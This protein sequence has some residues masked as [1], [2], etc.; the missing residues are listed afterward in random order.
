MA[1]T[2]SP[3]D[4]QHSLTAEVDFDSG[5]DDRSLVF[6]VA[7]RAYACQVSAVREVVPLGRVTRLPG[8]PDSVLGLINVRGSIVTVVNA[9]AVLHPHDAGAPLRMVLIADVGVRGVGLAVERVADV[10]ALRPEEGYTELDVR[11]VAMRVVAI[12]EDE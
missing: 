12:S 1:S 11:D 10:R 7:G 6:R 3:S 9:G 2:I 5:L 4:A 8:A